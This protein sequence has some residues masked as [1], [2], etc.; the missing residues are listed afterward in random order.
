[1]D[2]L[3]TATR[4]V[5][6]CFGMARAWTTDTPSTSANTRLCM[7]LQ[8]MSR[9]WAP[10][11]QCCLLRP[12]LQPRPLHRQLFTNWMTWRPCWIPGCLLTTSPW[13]LATL[14]TAPSSTIPTVIFRSTPVWRL[15]VQASGLWRW[16]LQVWFL[17]VDQTN[18]ARVFFVQD[19]PSPLTSPVAMQ[20]LSTT[21]QYRRLIPRWAVW[22]YHSRF[23]K[24]P[25]LLCR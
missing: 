15:P 21:A 16:P 8:S 10:L 6:P 3:E 2:T 22:F 9:N 5:P 19:I 23:A 1:M 13:W 20:V 25:A 12:R 11:V 7:M 17:L 18:N 4:Q 14:S 24:L